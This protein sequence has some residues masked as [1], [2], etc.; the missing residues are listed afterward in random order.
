[1]IL[2]KYRNTE[3]SDHLEKLTPGSWIWKNFLS[4]EEI[5]DIQD[6]VAIAQKA[7]IN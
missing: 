5:E 1:M 3:I 7:T 6:L 4:K 2:Y